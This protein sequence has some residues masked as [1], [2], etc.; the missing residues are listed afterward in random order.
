MKLTKDSINA[1]DLKKLTLTDS[2]MT[3]LAA[4]AKNP[5]AMAKAVQGGIN[6]AFTQLA[7]AL[8]ELGNKQSAGLQNVANNMPQPEKGPDGK[9]VVP[10]G[11]D[12]KT[13]AEMNKNKALGEN[14]MQKDFIAA[15]TAY[16]AAK[17]SGR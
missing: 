15:L 4:I 10:T 1:M 2:L 8:E 12:A 9:P 11:P 3:S 6:E 17:Q 5:E 7:K 14:N 13:K 16:G